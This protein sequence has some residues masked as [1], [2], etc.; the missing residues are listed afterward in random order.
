MGAISSLKRVSDYIY[1]IPKDFMSDMRVPARLFAS[2]K[3][4]VAIGKD[5]SLEQLVNTATL[6]GIER[7]AMA[8][9][10]IHEGYG[11]PIGG[12]VATRVED[13]IISPG[14]VGYDINCGVRL[15]RSEAMV[16]DVKLK[17]EELATQLQ[18]DVPS[19]LG[20]GGP[21]VLS[22]QRLDEVMHKGVSWMLEQG[23]GEQGDNTYCEAQG[24]LSDA[25][26]GF[27]SSRAKKRGRDQLGTIGSGNHFAEIERVD[28]VFDEGAAE[29]LGLFKDQV[30]F[31]VHCGSRGLGHQ[32][33]TDYIRQFMPKLSGW[34][35]VLPDRELVGAPFHT[36][37]GQQYFQ[38]MNAAANFAFANRH[39]IMHNIRGAWQKIFGDSLGRLSL[40]YDV[41]HNMAKMENHL[42]KQLVVHRKG[43]TRD[44]EPDSPELPKEYGAV[45]QP[46]LIPGSM[47][48]ASFV[49]VGTEKAEE[50]S[51]ATTCHGA[52]RRMSRTQAS[53][54][55]PYEE[56]VRN[57]KQQGIVVRSGSRRGLVEEA[58]EA[59][60]D[61]EEVVRVVHEVGIA[62]RVVRLKPL[63][64]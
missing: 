8:M 42:G 46:V 3:L 53:K 41:A 6:P 19:G 15:I 33:A 40:V 30:V 5:R 61:V 43:A 20:R 50:L 62:K 34:G 54:Q 44:F 16:S 60:K 63:A 32:V 52:G 29:T 31:L 28:E 55:I 23:Y 1:E 37:D 57:M 12:V 36:K 14:G 7:Y 2:E 10:D 9:P 58:P 59:Y 35:I 22:E 47:G 56:L 25:D 26:P 51:F 49:L 45:G 48:T 38:A 64:V 13:G 24:T 11:F 18:H 17:L 39:F 4:L 21:L 27:V